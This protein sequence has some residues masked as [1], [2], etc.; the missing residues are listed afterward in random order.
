MGP[1]C[2][3]C[4]AAPEQVDGL[5]PLEEPALVGSPPPAVA[6]PPHAEPARAVPQS[7]QRAG[8]NRAMLPPPS[9]DRGARAHA[10]VPRTP[11]RAVRSAGERVAPATP[12]T[13]AIRGSRWLSHYLGE[14]A[15]APDAELRRFFSA[16]EG[17][18]SS[19]VGDGI[20]KRVE[21]LPQLL[22][23]S[24]ELS[25]LGARMYWKSLRG[26]LLREEA[27][28]GR[29]TFGALLADDAMHRALLAICFELVDH[30]LGA[31]ARPFPAIPRAFGVGDFEFFVMLENFVRDFDDQLP[32]G[33][34]K[35]LAGL[36]ALILDAPIW[37]K[38]E[39]PLLSHLADPEAA[40]HFA[41]PIDAPAAGCAAA[42]GAPPPSPYVVRAVRLPGVLRP[43]QRAKSA[44]TPSADAPPLAR[45]PSADAVPRA[46]V[47]KQLACVG[48]RVW[49]RAAEMLGALGRALQAHGLSERAQAR[50][51]QVMRRILT[52]ARERELLANR[53]LHQ[54][55]MCVV[56][57]VARVEEAHGVTFRTIIGEHQELFHDVPE[58]LYWCV[59]VGPHRDQT[60]NLIEFYNRKFIPAC[61]ELLLD[62]PSAAAL[63]AQTFAAP[64]PPRSPPVRAMPMAPLPMRTPPVSPTDR[65]VPVRSPMRP[66]L[67]PLVRTPVRGHPRVTVSPM[68]GNAPHM[69]P[70]TKRLYTFED[71]SIGE[72]DDARA[73]RMRSAATTPWGVA[74]KLQ[75]SIDAVAPAGAPAG[76]PGA[77]PPLR[78]GAASPHSLSAALFASSGGAALD[79]TPL[80]AAA[81]GAAPL[82]RQRSLT[83]LFEEV[84]KDGA[85]DPASGGA[86]AP[87]I[88]GLQEPSKK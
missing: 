79:L 73:K 86:A 13:A 37:V 18:A 43:E 14:E 68:R 45:T 28:L 29:S 54:I 58:A 8:Q 22:C 63:A 46:Q 36:R 65:Q 5:V 1:P 3:T 78:A 7:P 56:F 20:V 69:T 50:A 33:S 17:E 61:K 71:T 66:P 38:E 81:G 25:D 75:S 2:L 60:G 34:R 74:S 15:A 88:F 49:Q 11:E 76:A 77:S 82:M 23:I 41:A 55:V 87:N 70:R 6:T 19:G 59:Q 32:P 84:P 80:P 12:M 42:A 21:E 72:V 52:S 31:R 27:R 62:E 9:P 51:A 10:T 85:A 30:A 39:S 48:R 16:C 57:G 44:C 24:G 53:S 4:R 40:R 26:I 35:H 64:V 67:S 83:A 47:H